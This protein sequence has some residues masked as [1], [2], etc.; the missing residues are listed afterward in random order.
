ME[1]PTPVKQPGSLLHLLTTIAG[2]AG[3]VLAGF[4]FPIGLPAAYARKA[5]IH[6]FLASLPGFGQGH[7]A[8][9]YMPAKKSDEISLYRP[10]YPDKPGGSRRNHLVSGLG[11]PFHKLFRLCEKGHDNRGPACPLF[12]T[13]GGQQVGKAAIA[14]WEDMITPALADPTLKVKVWPFS[15]TMG[16]C[17]Q[18]NHIIIVETYP[19]EFY[20][21]LGISFTRPVRRSKRRQADR[22]SFANGLLGWASDHRL[23]L[24]TEITAEIRQGFGNARQG[25]DRFDALAGLYGMINVIQG[26]HACGEPLATAISKVEGWIFGQEQSS[27]G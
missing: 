2:E 6:D 20:G 17:C 13:M 24:T 16:E 10:F 22:I 21:Q 3:C 14:G 11:I 26:N 23:E 27:Q 7:W 9:F 1:G 4:D 12:W 15:G 5:G 18:P 19:T 25:E 8:Q